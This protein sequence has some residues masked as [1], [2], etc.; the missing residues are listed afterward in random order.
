MAKV[1]ITQ[2]A[3]DLTHALGIA[4]PK[5]ALLSAVETVTPTIQSTLDAAA[6]CK[7][8]DRGQITGARFWMARWPLTT[9]SRPKP[10]TKHIVPRGGH[11]P[12]ILVV[13]DLESAICWPSSCPTWRRRPRPAL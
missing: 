13:P 3:I 10:P 1:D 7:M 2:N 6:L 4:R 11:D 5:V 9:P 12:D 8:A